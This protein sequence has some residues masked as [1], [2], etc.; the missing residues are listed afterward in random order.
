MHEIPEPSHPTVQTP[1]S[2]AASRVERSIDRTGLPTGPGSRELPLSHSVNANQNTGGLQIVVPMAG[3]GQRFSDAGYRVPKPLIP[4]CGEPMV[5]RVI[6]DLPPAERIVF[7]CLQAHI[8]QYNIERVLAEHC[9]GSRIV[10]TPGLTAGQACS[11]LLARSELD[12]HRPVLVAACD[13]T[14]LYQ[15]AVWQQATADPQVDALIWTYRG[16]PRVLVCPSWFGWVRADDRGNVQ[17]VSVKQPISDQPLHDPVVSG[18]FWFRTAGLMVQG[19][20]RLME[21][22]QRVNNEFYLDSV[23]N[24]LIAGGKRVKTFEVDKYIGWGTPDALRD[25]E[26]LGRYYASVSQNSAA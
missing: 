7:V 17:G 23:A 21:T 15:R 9:P 22:D 20:D 24:C 26:A 14:H 5:V 12:M 2:H 18:C 25:F 10:S 19:I 16:D 13:N 11:V 1:S 8:D 6:R 3:L 4:V